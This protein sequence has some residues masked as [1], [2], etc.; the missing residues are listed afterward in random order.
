MALNPVII[1]HLIDPG[2][3]NIQ[4]GLER[5]A[6]ALKIL[7]NPQLTYPVIHITG[8]NGKGSTAA[9]IESGL[10]A[11]GFK[12]GKFTSPYLFKINESIVLNHNLISDRE[13]EEC[14]FAIYPHLMTQQIEL[15]PFEFLTVIMFYYFAQQNIDYLVLEVGM[16]GTHD[17]TNVVHAKF[18]IITNIELEHTQYF[19]NS[20]DAIATEKIGIIKDGSQVIIADS[21][22]ELVDKIKTKTTQYVNVLTKYKPQ[23]TLNNLDF[24]TKLQFIDNQQLKRYELHLFGKFQAYNFLCAYE[25]FKNL[26]IVEEHIQFAAKHPQV[27]GR[28]EIISY[29]PLQIIDAAHNAAGVKSLYMS[30]HGIYKPS[31]VVIVTAIL[32]DKNVPEMFTWLSKLSSTIICTSISDNRRSH[33]ASDLAMF[34]KEKFDDVFT[35]SPAQDALEFAK[36]LNKQMILITGSIYLLGEL[37]KSSITS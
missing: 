30:L 19:G 14:F 37:F 11:S 22:P 34:A 27:K 12:I 1:K 13:L 4:P 2:Y 28:L 21:K 35:I 32:I 3:A 7:D 15:S 17:A 9:F 25:I 10:L 29:N 5:M 26:G 18:S 8:T 36:K 31:N 20:L 23:I 16:G 24:T 33:L 6:T